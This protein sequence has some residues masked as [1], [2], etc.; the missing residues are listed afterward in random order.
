MPSSIP[1]FGSTAHTRTVPAA[2]AGARASRVDQI[3]LPLPDPVTPETSRW[4]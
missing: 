4:W 3:T 1:P 2:T